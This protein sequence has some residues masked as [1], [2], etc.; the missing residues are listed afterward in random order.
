MGPFGACIIVYSLYFKGPKRAHN[1]DQ[2]PSRSREL[3]SGLT[4]VGSQGFGVSS[5]SGSEA[6]QGLRF[7]V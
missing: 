1:F 4:S 5:G 7:R 6:K 2:P 3:V